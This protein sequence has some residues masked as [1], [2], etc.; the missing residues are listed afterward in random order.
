[1]TKIEHELERYFNQYTEYRKYNKIDLASS[2]ITEQVKTLHLGINLS[3]TSDDC[4][5]LIDYLVYLESMAVMVENGVI[6]LK[7]V[8]DLFSYR[9]FLAV[10]N[11]VVQEQELFPFAEFYKGTYVLSQKWIKDHRRK[12][13]SYSNGGILSYI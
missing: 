9:F 7:D 1:M 11:P 10:N 4:Q 3:R 12:K 5:M 6:K 8:D 13:D 2:G